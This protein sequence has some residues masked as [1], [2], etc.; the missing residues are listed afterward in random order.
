MTTITIQL[1]QPLAKCYLYLC[2]SICG[3]GIIASSN[4]QQQ[5]SFSQY[6]LN[7]LVFNPATAGTKGHTSVQTAY[8]KQW[9]S[10][11]G[12]PTTFMAYVQSPL[13][14]KAG[15]IG[16][17]AMLF[18]DEAAAIRRNGMALTYAQHFNI[19][20]GT[21]FSLGITGNAEQYSF[22]M[23]VIRKS[24]DAG[25]PLLNA[26]A[27]SKMAFDAGFSAYVYNERWSVGLYADNLLESRIDFYNNSKAKFFRHF[28][29]MAQ[30]EF[31]LDEDRNFTVLPAV[32]IKATAVAPIQ[33]D[34]NVNLIHQ[35]NKWIGLHY[36]NNQ[37]HQL[38]ANIGLL[39]KDKLVLGYAYDFAPPMQNK[40]NYGYNNAQEI[41]IG[42]RIYK[43]D[44]PELKNTRCPIF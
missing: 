19:N 36:R 3:I 37:T 35:D 6:H 39:I 15:H 5:Q 30:M 13:T 41:T 23:D 42:Y 14:I 43:E 31:E 38:S 8:R 9:T 25:D 4:A 20:D 32:L 29:G 2:L 40:F 11:E 10:I 33:I 12:A 7:D 16:L 18:H 17:G 21:A 24:L 1:Y 44:N 27:A 28:Y 22:N 34:F 26:P